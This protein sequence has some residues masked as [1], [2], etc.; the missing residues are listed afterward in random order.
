[1]ATS[2]YQSNYKIPGVYVTQSSTGLTSLGQTSLNIAIVV[3]QITQATMTENFYVPNPSNNIPIGVL[4]MPMVLTAS[5]NTVVQW[6]SAD[7]L[8]T[9]SGVQGTDY[10]LYTDNYNITSISTSGLTSS[11]LPSGNVSVTY[12]HQFG[13]YG[14]Y[15]SQNAVINAIGIPVSGTTVIN[16]ASLAAQMALQ[17]GATTVTIIPV[18]QCAVSGNQAY[19]GQATQSD[20]INAFTIVSGSRNKSFVSN[21]HGIDVVVPMYGFTGNGYMAPTGSGTVAS[22]ILNYINT[23]AANGTYQRVF[24]GVDGTSANITASGIQ[25]LASGFN[26]TRITLAFPGVLTYNPGATSYNNY[27]STSFQIEVTY[28]A[29]AL[30]A[31]FVSQ[32]PDVSTPIT[33]K[34]VNGFADIPNQISSVDARSSY[35]P[36]GVLVVR[37]KRDGNI[38]VLHG[39]TTKTTNF[40]D[41]EIS[42]NAIGDRL[43]KLIGTDLNNSYLVGGPLNK[44]T[45]AATLGNVQGTLTN[46]LS[47]GLIQ[48]YQNLSV[49]NSQATP[50]TLNVTFQYAPT[51]PLNYIQA[52]F[53][54]NT[55][56]GQIV[57]INAQSNTATY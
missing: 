9:Y 49:T 39:I 22:G 36:Y 12:N 37:K 10:V 13:A 33:N 24:A 4:S 41:A 1:M 5:G 42:I 35:L 16:P 40:V 29:P 51:Y 57:Y 34:I 26:S 20:W 18:T 2:S 7:G 43:A 27:I 3:D 45:I 32:T 31:L 38:W 28:L 30:A 11:N 17:N 15:T 54:L 6:T 53:S 56:T 48:A 21:T 50:T 44:T 25:A 8:T 23:Q 14:T 47:N 46:A 19:T 52:V 55:S